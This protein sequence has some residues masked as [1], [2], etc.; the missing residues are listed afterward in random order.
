[1]SA[2]HRVDEARALLIFLETV[3]VC[4]H[5]LEPQDVDRLQIGIH[6]HERVWIEQTLDPFAGGLRLM[7]VAAR[8]NTLI[9]RQLSIGHGLSAAGAF[10]KNAARHFTLLAGVCLD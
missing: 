2:N 9:L 3:L 8:T 6:L 10:L 1:M 5:S 4:R 7:I